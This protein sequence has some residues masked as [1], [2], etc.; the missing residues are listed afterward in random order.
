M[1][2]VPACG[3]ATRAGHGAFTLRYTVRIQRRFTHGIA[4]SV[5]RRLRYAIGWVGGRYTYFAHIITRLIH[6]DISCR[7]L[8]YADTRVVQERTPRTHPRRLSHGDCH[9]LQ[10]VGDCVHRTLVSARR[11]H[12]ARQCGAA[13][14]TVE[15]AHCATL[16]SNV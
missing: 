10:C 3:D 8:G 7:R 9:V 11:T 6:I 4:N 14:C 15:S 12:A 2:G 1:C 16:N 5:I 13:Q